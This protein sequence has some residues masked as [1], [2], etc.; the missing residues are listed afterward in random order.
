MRSRSA[1]AISAPRVESDVVIADPPDDDAAEHRVMPVAAELVADDQIVAG[2][3]N[4][5]VNW[6]MY[7]G[8]SIVLALVPR[9]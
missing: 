4:T 1:S 5:V 6:L 9:P 8:T 3:G 7:P 2:P